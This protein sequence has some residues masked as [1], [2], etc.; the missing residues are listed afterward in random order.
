MLYFLL[1]SCVKIL[2]SSLKGYGVYCCLGELIIGC[3]GST[4]SKPKNICETTVTCNCLICFVF[5]LAM[6][7]SYGREEQEDLRIHM[8]NVLDVV[9]RSTSKHTSERSLY[10]GKSGLVNTDRH[11]YVI[12]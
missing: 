9:K 4:A 1:H 12:I 11:F 10:Y 8:S 6:F 2:L 7:I 3:F 5:Q